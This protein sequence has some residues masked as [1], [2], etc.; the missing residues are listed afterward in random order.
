MKTETGVRNAS[1]INHK[2]IIGFIKWLQF[3]A[4][5][6]RD[7]GMLTFGEPVKKAWKNIDAIEQKDDD[8]IKQEKKWVKAVSMFLVPRIS[9]KQD[10]K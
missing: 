7:E 4:L 8:K 9:F 5:L 1:F 3:I 10:E 6:V 2:K